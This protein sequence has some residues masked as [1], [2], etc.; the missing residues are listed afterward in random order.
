MNYTINLKEIGEWAIDLL[1]SFA[2]YWVASSA[3]ME[4]GV[5]VSEQPLSFFASLG[6]TFAGFKLLRQW[7][8]LS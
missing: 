8:A 7:K 3:L 1:G 6:I 5:A 2:V 4:S